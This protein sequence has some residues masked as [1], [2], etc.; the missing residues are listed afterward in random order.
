MIDEAQ[1]E[2]RQLAGAARSDARPGSC[3]TG[4]ATCARPTRTRP[5]RI[6][7]RS[8]ARGWDQLAQAARHARADGT[9]WPNAAG[10]RRSPPIS[11]GDR[12][13]SGSTTSGRI[14]DLRATATGLRGFFLA[15]PEELSLL[16]LV[17]QFAESEQP[18]PARCFGSRAATTGCRPRWRRSSA[19][20]SSSAPSSSRS[21]CA[22]KSVHATLK[23][24]RTSAPMTSDY[25]VFAL[26]ASVLRRVP[27]TPALPAHQ[28][29]A[30]ATL[31]YGRATKTLL[32]FTR[33][34]WRAPRAAAGVRIAAAL[35]RDLGR[36]RGTGGTAGHPHAARRRRARATRRRRWSPS[37]GIARFANGLDVARRGQARALRLA[38]DRVGI[39]S[40]GARRLRVFRSGVRSDAARVARA[41]RRAGCSSPASTRASAGRAT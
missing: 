12:W 26:P 2:I 28:H 41:A 33:R 9:G 3:A 10:T 29:E 18:G 36:Q 40:A 22:G 21:R 23:R 8:V 25:L 14:A 31:K 27:I 30:I 24:G 13:R 5:P 19:I 38:T 20:A 37:E 4:S 35:R 17:D 39:G 6:V 16:A 11:P 1:D 32:Q 34:F 7:T 15:D